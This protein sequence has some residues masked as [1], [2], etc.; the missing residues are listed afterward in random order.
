MKIFSTCAAVILGAA[1]VGYAGFQ[2]G[3]SP[4]HNG[5]NSGKATAEVTP[6]RPRVPANPEETGSSSSPII[7]SSNSIHFREA[8]KNIHSFDPYHA[9]YDLDSHKAVDMV[10][11]LCP[12]GKAINPTNCTFSSGPYPPNGSFASPIP[13]PWTLHL[14]D[15]AGSFVGALHVDDK[16][17]PGFILISAPDFMHRMYS[18]PDDGSTTGEG[19]EI[20]DCTQL[21]CSSLMNGLGSATLS[22]SSG[23]PYNLTC[24]P[25]TGMVC[26]I[27]IRY[28]D[29]VKPCT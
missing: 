7:V 25:V 8:G 17:L 14:N 4:S 2:F 9:Y 27:Y 5:K 11:G 15:S 23:G 22:T 1:L 21:P 28:C 29:G 6:A 19:Y 24:M 3:C 20:R 26:D 12:K 16:G 18:E 10:M 13:A